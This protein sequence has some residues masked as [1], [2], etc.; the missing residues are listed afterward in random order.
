MTKK[1]RKREKVAI[2]VVVVAIFGEEACVLLEAN[3]GDDYSG[4][5]GLL[6]WRVLST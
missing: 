1:I 4:N 3:F 6:S 2:L 5:A